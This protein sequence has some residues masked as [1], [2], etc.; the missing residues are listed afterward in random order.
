M[1]PD[2]FFGGVIISVGINHWLIYTDDGKP[3]NGPF[4]S[5]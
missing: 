3:E 1:L 5:S 2:C 4:R